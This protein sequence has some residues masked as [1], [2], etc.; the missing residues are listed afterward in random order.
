MRVLIV[1]EGEHEL[2]TPAEPDC[3]ALCELIR[4]LLPPE[5]EVSIE[6]RRIRDFRNHVHGK[7]SGL[8]KKLIHILQQAQRQGFDALC[9]LIDQDEQKSRRN[10]INLAQQ[11][12]QVTIP[13]A[14]GLAVQT[15][16]AWFLADHQVLGEVLGQRI[17][18]QPCPE[19]LRNPKA[20]IQAFLQRT[21]V[22]ESQRRLYHRIAER[23]DLSKLATQ[24]P[25]GFAPFAERVKDLFIS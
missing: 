24:C 4:R 16:D 18:L 13:R 11:Y 19:Q 9:L 17:P 14:L 6:T 20:E 12:Q 21:N 10:D 5:P 1:S 3:C 22:S 7:G 15:F 2:G 8:F 23:L 25:D